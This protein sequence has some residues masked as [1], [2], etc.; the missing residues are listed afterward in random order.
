MLNMV[1]GYSGVLH[2]IMLPSKTSSDLCAG[3]Y[4]LLK[5]FEAVPK[6]LV[7]DNEP[8]IGR[9]H[10]MPEVKLFKGALGV[11]IYQAKVRDPE[12]KGKVERSVS[13]CRSSFIPGRSF[14]SITDFNVQIA[15]WNASVANKRKPRGKDK[16][17]A[18]WLEDKKAMDVFNPDAYTPGLTHKAKLGRDYYL[19]VLGNDYSCDPVFIG[20]KISI[21]ADLEHVMF[22]CG[23]QIAGFHERCFRLLA[24][25]S[26]ERNLGLRA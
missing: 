15:D 12:A 7:W 23:D 2:S 1:A 9:H 22:T 14:D 25:M 24:R 4:E 8:G 20:Q 16:P 18:M 11:D 10:F 3:M 5:R 19:R 26:R 21:L 6:K 17:E 13:Y